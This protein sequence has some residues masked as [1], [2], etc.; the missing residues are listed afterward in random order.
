MIFRGT[1]VR[2]RQSLPAKQWDP[3]GFRIRFRGLGWRV[4]G[5]RTV[6][7]QVLC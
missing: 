2:V 3:H 4:I 6:P 1:D 7:P 5:I